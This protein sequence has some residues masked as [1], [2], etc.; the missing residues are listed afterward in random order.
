[1]WDPNPNPNPKISTAGIE[2]ATSALKPIQRYRQTN[3]RHSTVKDND[4][5]SADR[6][7]VFSFTLMPAAGL[8]IAKKCLLICIL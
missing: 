4:F 6:T 3:N 2:A 8:S 7:K 5:W 1:M